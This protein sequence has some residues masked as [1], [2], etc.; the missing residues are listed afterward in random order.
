[1]IRRLNDDAVIDAVYR[2]EPEVWLKQSGAIK[3][4]EQTGRNLL[5]GYANLER[6]GAIDVNLERRIVERLGNPE[7][8]Q[9]R[10]PG[11]AFGAS[12]PM[13]SR[14]VR[15]SGSGDLHID[16]SRETEIQNL[17]NDVGSLEVAY[18]RATDRQQSARI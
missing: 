10:N 6:F 17:A 1:M 16:R 5:F 13:R 8:G 3:L 4:G 9:A 15:G 12:R 14:S 11:S 2:I 7:I 18:D